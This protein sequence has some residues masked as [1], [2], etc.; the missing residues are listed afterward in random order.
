MSTRYT[1]RD[2]DCI[3]S[4]AFERGFFPDTVWEHPD[5]ASLRQARKDNP[6]ALL[7]GDQVVIPDKRSREVTAAT[8]RRHTFRRRGV[9]AVFRVRVL[10]GGEPLAK[11]PFTLDV[12][13][14]WI[15]G[16]TTEEGV[17]EAMIPPNAA[18]ARLRVGDGEDVLE[19]TFQLGGLDPADSPSGARQRLLNLGYLVEDET[20]DTDLAGAL[21]AFQKD[22]GLSVTGELDGPTADELAARHDRA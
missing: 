9:P 15:Q 19:Y 14:A 6:N 5:N 3:S 2:G 17:V 18:V 10:F 1:V 7:A 21:S 13:G 4:I 8:G 12:G 11:E 22:S 20:S 16:T